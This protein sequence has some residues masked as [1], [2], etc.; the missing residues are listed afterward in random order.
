M[1]VVRAL[2]P[3]LN[4]SSSSYKLP[5]SGGGIDLRITI[6]LFAGVDLAALS[7]PLLDDASFDSA[8]EHPDTALNHRKQPD[9]TG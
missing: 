9:P 4:F 7:S 2:S 5:D 1:V 8:V 6:V 3:K